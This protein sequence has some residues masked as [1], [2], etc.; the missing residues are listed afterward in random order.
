MGF[1]KRFSKK[2]EPS[3]NKTKLVP[4]IG[5]IPYPAYRGKRPYI[6]VSYSHA[7]S[8]RVFAE[9]KRFNEAGFRVWYDQGIKPG[10]EWPDE[11]ANALENCK[12]FVVFMTRNSV[13]SSNVADEIHFVIEKKMP[14][15]AIYLEEC[16]LPS[17]LMLRFNRKQ[18]IMKYLLT[19]EEYDYQYINAFEEEGLKRKANRSVVQRDLAP[20]AEATGK[21]S[22]ADHDAPRPAYRGKDDY[23]FVS[24]AR[25]EHEIVYKVINRFNE[26]GFNVWYDEGTAPGNEW[27]AGISN[28]LDRCSL[29]VVMIT[30]DSMASR[31]VKNEINFALKKNK[32]FIAIYLKE[33]ELSPEMELMIGCVM[34]IR[35]Y[36]MSEE[37]FQDRFIKAFELH[38][39]YRNES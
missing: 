1:F 9:I 25:S 30:P 26:A 5:R 3:E 37:E 17:G 12:L 38:G 8:E 15:I 4:G 22:A 27:P 33:T 29:Y 39:L 20:S 23:I 18:A 13:R 16:E 35:K 6:F 31:N 11:I 36:N 21:D 19:D 7:D 10:S 28:A 14:A 24:Y 32:P 2:K 34:A